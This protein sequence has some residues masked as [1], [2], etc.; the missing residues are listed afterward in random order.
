[1]LR[2]WNTCV[3]DGGFLLHHVTWSDSET[4]LYICKKYVQYI[5]A[6]YGDDC[7]PVFDGYDAET[8]CTKKCE[9]IQRSRLCHS[10]GIYFDENTLVAVKQSVFL[11]NSGNKSRFITLLHEKLEDPGVHTI[12]SEG[13][14]NRNIVETAIDKY[15]DSFID[16][17][18]T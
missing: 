12:L 7:T 17:W 16:I 11:T 9:K 18:T 13:D 2:Q 5:K 15:S 3:I 4:F 6:H 1:M 10:V 14:A 8:N